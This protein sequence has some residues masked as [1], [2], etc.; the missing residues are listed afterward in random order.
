MENQT[1]A[2]SFPPFPP[3]QMF[4]TSKNVSK[5][6]AETRPKCVAARQKTAA[7]N[8]KRPKDKCAQIRDAPAPG[9]VSA[10]PPAGT[11]W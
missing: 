10:V 8:G 7:E 9:P 1:L 4:L 11:F 5:D 6:A 3:N 2:N